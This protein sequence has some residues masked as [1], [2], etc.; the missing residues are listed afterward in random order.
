MSAVEVISRLA[1]ALFLG[2]LLGLER[3]WRHR[4]VGLQTNSLVSLGAALFVMLASL[5]PDDSSPSRIAAQVVSGVG[6]LAGGVILREGASVHG[7]N[8]AATLWCAAAIGAMAGSGH[9]AEAC[10]GSGLVF[11]A[12]VILRPLS[13]RIN[14]QPIHQADIEIWYNCCITCKRSSETHIRAQIV[15]WLS[16]NRLG[17]RSLVSQPGTDTQATVEAVII[18]RQRDDDSIERLISHLSLESDVF[19]ASWYLREQRYDA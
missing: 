6:F 17:L 3:Q 8:T 19:A 7:L 12:N 1:I 13:R 5:T 14:R 10:A 4:S 18:A 2:I 11:M 15:Q 9:I 16:G